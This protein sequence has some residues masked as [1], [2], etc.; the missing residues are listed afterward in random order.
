MMKMMRMKRMV[1]SFFC[2]YSLLVA[3]D[4]FAQRR[5]DEERKR[6]ERMRG[7]RG[8]RRNRVKILFAK[9]E[10]RESSKG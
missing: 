2:L 8:M 3:D 9:V 7:E 5:K 4:S 1:S 6:M 10:V